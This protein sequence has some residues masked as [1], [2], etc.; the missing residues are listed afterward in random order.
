MINILW[1]N[2]KWRFQNPLSI[3]VTILQPLLWLI[4]YSVV[5]G[6][7]MTSVGI[8]HYTAFMLPGIIVLVTFSSCSSSGIINY[9]NKKSGAFYR[10]LISPIRRTSIIFGQTFEAIVLAF[11]EILVLCVVG[12]FLSVRFSC[13]LSGLLVCLILMVLT[14]FFVANLAYSISLILPNEVI[15]ETVM[16]SIVLPI[17]FMSTALVPQEDLSGSLKVIVELNPFTHVINTLRN[18]ILYGQ[19]EFIS[20]IKVIILMLALCIVIFLVAIHRLK[21]ETIS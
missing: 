12:L 15:Y 5:A 2:M 17:F 14:A 8:E 7:T 20:S 19:V 13:G 9:L 10:I 1:R 16:N 11:F 4:M 3:L 21:K 6:Q 18:A